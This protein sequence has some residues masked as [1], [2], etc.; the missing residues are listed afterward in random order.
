[1]RILACLAVPL[2]RNAERL[3]D[4]LEL[5]GQRGTNHL[6]IPTGSGEGFKLAPRAGKP[7]GSSSYARQTVLG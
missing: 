3:A 1:M 5:D 2:W 6:I 4:D 7:K